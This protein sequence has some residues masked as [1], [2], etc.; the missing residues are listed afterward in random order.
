MPAAEAREELVLEEFDQR[1]SLTPQSSKLMEPR[2]AVQR[3]FMTSG[4]FPYSSPM[5][6]DHQLP[7][8]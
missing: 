1:V 3:L 5:S 4:I 8:Q 7:E 6:S 2:M